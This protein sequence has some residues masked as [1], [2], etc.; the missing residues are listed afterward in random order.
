MTKN[1]NS[2]KKGIDEI[3][4][5]YKR[6]HDSNSAYAIE[7]KKETYCQ[8]INGILQITKRL[9]PGQEF[10]EICAY[11]GDAMQEAELIQ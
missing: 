5:D 9:V 1:G 4:A 11:A 10:A 6:Y 7:F 8:R 3:C 2:I